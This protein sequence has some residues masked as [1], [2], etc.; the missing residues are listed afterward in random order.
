MA[1]RLLSAAGTPTGTY[2]SGAVGLVAAD[3][4]QIGELLRDMI[5]CW[6]HYRHTA[7]E[8]SRPW[9]QFHN[10]RRIVELLLAAADDRSLSATDIRA[11]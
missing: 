9:K 11:A 7:A 4:A 3:G 2:P 5:S 10:P 1:F 8:F 6:T